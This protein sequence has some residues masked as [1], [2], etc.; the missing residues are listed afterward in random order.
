MLGCLFFIHTHTMAQ[1]AVNAKL[2]EQFETEDVRTEK[3]KI[4]KQGTEKNKLVL[5]L[6]WVYGA[7]IFGIPVFFLPI[8]DDVF[9]LNKQT[10]LFSGTLIV[11]IFYGT[12]I[13]TAQTLR[14]RGSFLSLAL[15]LLTAL[16]CVASIFSLYRYAS[17]V[18]L[19]GQASTSLATLVCLAALVFIGTT[20]FTARHIVHLMRVMIGS[21]T[22]LSLIGVLQL[23]GVFLLPWEIL[24]TGLVYPAGLINGLGITASLGLVLSI[25]EILR[26]AAKGRGASIMAQTLFAII[27][28]LQLIVL[29]IFDDVA[30]WASV[31]ASLFFMLV[32]LFVKLSRE[33][34]ISWLVLPSFVLVFSLTMIFVN[35][36]RFVFPLQSPQLSLQTSA[37]IAFQSLQERPY[38]GYGPGN[39]GIAYT[40]FRPTE[41]NKENAGRI[42]A[43]RFLQSGSYLA[44]NVVGTGLLGLCALLLFFGTLAFKAL[45]LLVRE[46]NGDEYALYLGVVGSVLTLGILG[47]LKP[48]DFSTTFL[49]WMLVGFFSIICARPLIEIRGRNSNRFI[50]LSSLV[51]FTIIS[52]SL[53]GAL[54]ASIRY[55]ADV[56]FHE[57]SAKDRILSERI[58]SGERIEESEI[59]D[60]IATLERAMRMNT[61]HHRYPKALSQALVYKT[62]AL[63]TDSA[64]A[65]ENILNIRSLAA[66]A[67]SA[68]Q[69]A[70]VLS[71][72]DAGNMRNLADTLGVVF[73]FVENGYA[74]AQQAYGE[75]IKL[76][77]KNPLLRVSFAKLYLSS[78]LIFTQQQTSIE[79]D[80][81]KK[82]AKDA[83]KL[84]LKEAER[85]LSEAIE[86]KQDYP[87]PYFQLGTIAATKNKKQ[88]ALAY[89]D[90]ALEHNF[91][92]I[93]LRASDE[94]LFYNLGLNYETLQ[95]KDKAQTAY[96]LAVSLRP[97]YYL[98]LWRS[99][100]LD[101]EQGNNDAAIQTL[102]RIIEHDPQNEI[103][104]EKI[105]TLEN[106]NGGV[107]EQIE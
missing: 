26:L 4:K 19:E 65:R 33:Q 5:F 62:S 79:K 66:Q 35:V 74:I 95:A 38:L 37:G 6:E 39:F 104:K 88:D 77:P 1:V 9:D 60:L 106:K 11:C 98:A 81:E 72:K 44:T 68:A 53:V 75:S 76:D 13:V 41:I 43:E 82:L 61:F 91:R 8:T 55:A 69:Q 47:A 3:R 12:H 105:K 31:A 46:K 45:G 48:I 14:I 58:Q 30:L 78:Y 92:L 24:K 42:W 83:S 70:I 16:W 7:L 59:N 29:V 71:N 28:G 51:L 73:P 84:A 23:F 89:F 40:Q 64:R 22:V 80:E 21:T 50:I 57:A 18:G 32:F 96:K 36:P 85:L 90:T 97:N 25:A 10:L 93:P 49:F 15:V 54:F 2:V 100:L 17:F 27:T 56:T 94:V 52:V 102:K 20:V 86:L 34:K 63:A 87:E 99:A 103:V 101:E 67:V 107:S